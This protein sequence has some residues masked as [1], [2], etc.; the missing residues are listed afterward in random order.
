MR[1]NNAPVGIQIMFRYPVISVVSGH[2]KS[3]IISALGQNANGFPWNRSDEEV[4]VN[5]TYKLYICDS[6]ELGMPRSFEEEKFF[7][8]TVTQANHQET[9]I[10]EGKV[11]DEKIHTGPT[12]WRRRIRLQGKKAQCFFVDVPELIPTTQSAV[13][14]DFRSLIDQ[15]AAGRR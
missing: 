11:E 9:I 4:T 1:Q 13:T 6:V 5:S 7:R 2:N 10:D 14:S 12:V 3:A 8:L 15:I